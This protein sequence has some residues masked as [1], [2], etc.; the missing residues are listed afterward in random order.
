MVLNR[1]DRFGFVF[2]AFVRAV[3]QSTVSCDQVCFAQAVFIHSI[4]MILA[5]QADFAGC[6]ILHRMICAA[7]AEFHF[8]GCRTTG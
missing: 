3:V 5:R 6:K 1:E 4:A 7:V 8:V 2:D